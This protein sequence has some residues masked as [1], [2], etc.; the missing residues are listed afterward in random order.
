MSYLRGKLPFFKVLKAVLV[1]TYCSDQV[2]CSHNFKS[3]IGRA[4]PRYLV[5]SGLDWI[6]FTPAQYVPLSDVPYVFP[7]HP[8]PLQIP[9]GTAQHEAIRLRAEHEDAIALFREPLDVKQALIKQ[10]CQC[11]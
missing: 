6:P 9:A 3:V 1:I 7:P 11:P 8:G 10:N 5:A 4:K 2:F